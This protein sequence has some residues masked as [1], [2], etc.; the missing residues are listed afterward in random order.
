MSFPSF[1]QAIEGRAN[2]SDFILPSDFRPLRKMNVCPVLLDAAEFSAACLYI[3]FRVHMEA[4][5]GY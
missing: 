1:L 2:G 5:D 4:L 3:V